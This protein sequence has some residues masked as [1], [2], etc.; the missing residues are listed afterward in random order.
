MNGKLR[1]YYRA[2]VEL[3]KDFENDEVREKV[4][5]TFESLND[6]EKALIRLSL[7]A[8]LAEIIF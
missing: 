4:A 7:N 8:E 5:N 1:M 3:H 2:L 6:D